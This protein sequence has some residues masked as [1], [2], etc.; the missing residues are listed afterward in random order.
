[1]NK[2][3]KTASG[4]LALVFAS[5]MSVSLPVLADDLGTPFDDDAV[6]SQLRSKGV[7]VVELGVWGDKIRATVVLRDGS[8]EFQFFDSATLNRVQTRDTVVS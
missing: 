3:P 1:M 2:S 4:L 7:H 5:A 8:T 6:M